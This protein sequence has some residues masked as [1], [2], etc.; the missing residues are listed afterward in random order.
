MLLLYIFCMLVIYLQITSKQ[1]Q[2]INSM[3]EK[4][5]LSA[6]ANN[7]QG[8]GAKQYYPF[9]LLLK[10]IGSILLLQFTE[11][12][13]IST[14]KFHSETW[15]KVRLATIGFGTIIEEELSGR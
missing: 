6:L 10:L 4:K 12:Y 9:Q 13:I 1:K 15:Q 7:N 14:I 11:V 3:Y 8:K 5:S 2:K